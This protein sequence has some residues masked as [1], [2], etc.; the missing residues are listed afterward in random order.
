MTI[1]PFGGLGD[2]LLRHPLSPDGQGSAYHRLCRIASTLGQIGP[3]ILLQMR[4]STLGKMELSS[5]GQ[6]RSLILD[7]T[8]QTWIDKLELGYLNGSQ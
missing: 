1:H 3:F 5:L 8:L 4:F 7:V 6:R 2:L